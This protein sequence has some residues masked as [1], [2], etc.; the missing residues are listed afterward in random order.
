V[1]AWQQQWAWCGR[2]HGGPVA[3]LDRHWY[4]L[5]CIVLVIVVLTI[6]LAPIPSSP[7]YSR[8]LI[9]V[10]GD[11]VGIVVLGLIVLL[12]LIWLSKPTSARRTRGI[13]ELREGGEL[14]ETALARSGGAMLMLLASRTLI[15]YYIIIKNDL[16]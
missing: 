9:V 10:T 7:S 4:T 3:L 15:S 11:A 13:E 12:S 1:A 8:C 6:S 2:C 5:R 16:K 14:S